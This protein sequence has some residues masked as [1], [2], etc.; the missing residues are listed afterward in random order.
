MS[1]IRVFRVALSFPHGF[2]TGA[3]AEAF[4]QHP[5]LLDRRGAP[6]IR[7]SSVKGIFRRTAT[8]LAVGED[9]L[10]ALLGRE[11][12]RSDR[13][14]RFSGGKLT[15][16]DMVVDEAHASAGEFITLRHRTRRLPETLSVD[17][18]ARM[19]ATIETAPARIRMVA[20]IEAVAPNAEEVAAVHAVLASWARHGA[21]FGG[22]LAAGVGFGRVEDVRERAFDLDRADELHLWLATDDGR[23]R[24]GDL[25][26]WTAVDLGDR[27]ARTEAGRFLVL[28]GRLVL[29]EPMLIA[30]P[31]VRFPP[32]RPEGLAALAWDHPTDMAFARR[33]AAGRTGPARF[34][35]EVYV[36]GSSLR[37]AVRG[38]CRRVAGS[39]AH[40]VERIDD[41]FGTQERGSRLHVADGE[42]EGPEPPPTMIVDS[43]ALDRIGGM[44]L[45]GRKFDAE[46]LVEGAF[47]LRITVEEP[48]PEDWEVLRP[49]VKDLR[50]GRFWVG[51]GGSRGLGRVRLDSTGI[52]ECPAEMR[53]R[54]QRDLDAAC[55][56]TGRAQS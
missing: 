34:G 53:E 35:E 4:V 52:P 10:A 20:V 23:L 12:D 13:D 8:A 15:F 54:I 44:A 39:D 37:G 11:V 6:T 36:P 28:D 5:L 2:H 49:A 42:Y 56:A 41:L 47:R 51:K 19:L 9:V 29:E 18:E 30:E 50:H 48:C 22:K 25:Q 40:V 32:R 21:P 33:G 3:D 45:S 16:L 17:S 24:R 55:P 31:P 38:L 43:V 27:D 7:G 46:I 1:E 14:E 26:G